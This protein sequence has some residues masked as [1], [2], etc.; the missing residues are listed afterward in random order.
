MMKTYSKIQGI[1]VVVTNKPITYYHYADSQ[2][3][4]T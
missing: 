1:P 3:I 2:T 4:M